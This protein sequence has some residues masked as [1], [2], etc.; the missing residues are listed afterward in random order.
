MCGSPQRRI[1]QAGYFFLIQIVLVMRP[2]F[3]L[4]C[5]IDLAMEEG[6]ERQVKV[7]IKNLAV[8]FLFP[9]KDFLPISFK[10]QLLETSGQFVL[11]RHVKCSL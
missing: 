8:F 11:L 3:R 7:L 10:I 2:K 1:S 5:K 4:V 6:V 9:S